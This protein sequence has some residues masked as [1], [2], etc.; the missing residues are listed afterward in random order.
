MNK[1]G[2][3][4]TEIDGIVFDSGREARRYSQLKL[5]ERAGEI[6]DLKLQVKYNLIPRQN[7]PDGKIIERPVDYIADFVYK[8]AAGNTVVEDA[9]GRKT[10]EYIIKRKLMLYVHGI[11]V[12]EV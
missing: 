10:K 4:K 1:Y 5:M 2:A 9:K 6:R 7:K 12:Q 11:R 3:R 8:D